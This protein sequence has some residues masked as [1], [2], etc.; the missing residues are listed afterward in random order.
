[1]GRRH[2]LLEYEKDIDNNIKE[3]KIEMLSLE[4]KL[5]LMKK[6]ATDIKLE[7]YNLKKQGFVITDHALLRYV[8][9]VL[10]YDISALRDYLYKSIVPKD[11]F[12]IDGKYPI[13]GG[14]RIVV[15]NNKAVTVL[16]SKEVNCED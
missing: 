14:I 1:M 7:L 15:T 13:N 16:T 12:I 5:A 2:D 8:E 3:A 10:H 6:K 4:K 11:G 9:R